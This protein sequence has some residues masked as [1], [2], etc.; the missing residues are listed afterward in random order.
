M[1]DVPILSLKDG[2]IWSVSLSDK[3]QLFVW[4]LFCMARLDGRLNVNS[5]FLLYEELFCV[6]NQITQTQKVENSEVCSII[7]QLR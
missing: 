4:F 6:V 2:A 5:C 1:C 3:V 7:L